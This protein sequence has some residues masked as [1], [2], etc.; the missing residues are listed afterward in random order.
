MLGEEVV[1][2]AAAAAEG[3]DTAENGTAETGAAAPADGKDLAAAAAAAAVKAA[4]EDDDFEKAKQEVR[5]L[6]IGACIYVDKERRS[7]AYLVSLAYAFFVPVH[8]PCARKTI[9]YVRRFYLRSPVPCGPLLF[10][11]GLV[12][13]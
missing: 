12:A 11:I 9:F 8:R 13:T 7:E 5:R 10:N 6:L 1:P 4:E 3:A 2:A